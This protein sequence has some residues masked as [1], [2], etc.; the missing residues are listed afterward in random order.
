MSRCTQP[1]VNDKIICAKVCY[2][3]FNDNPLAKFLFNDYVL[4]D[5]STYYDNGIDSLREVRWKVYVGNYFF[6]DFG[7]NNVNDIVLVLGNG[8]TYG[9]LDLGFQ[10][11]DIIA[12]FES[13]PSTQVPVGTKFCIQLDVRDN[14]GVESNNISNTYCFIK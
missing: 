5:D 12:L 7:W 11:Q 10:N 1:I 8:S 2:Q 4:S 9:Q 3:Q 13:L 14:S 6:Y